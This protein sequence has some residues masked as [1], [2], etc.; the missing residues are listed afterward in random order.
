MGRPRGFVPQL[1]SLLAYQLPMPKALQLEYR[2]PDEEE[3]PVPENL[4]PGALPPPL[5]ASV[6]LEE[7]DVIFKPETEDDEQED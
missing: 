3:P 1:G 2:D 4:E 6:M 5:A 7:K